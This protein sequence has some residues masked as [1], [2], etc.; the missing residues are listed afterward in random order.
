LEEDPANVEAAAL[1][2][3]HRGLSTVTR[4]YNQ[5]GTAGAN[6]VWQRLLKQ[7]T[8]FEDDDSPHNS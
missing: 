2:L 6:L 3:G 5:N 4:Y 1:N 8:I 7:K